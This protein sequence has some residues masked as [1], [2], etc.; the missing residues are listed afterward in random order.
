MTAPASGD[1]AA[2][3]RG[4]LLTGPVFPMVVKFGVPTMARFDDIH[5]N[6]VIVDSVSSAFPP[7]APGWAALSPKTRSC[8]RRC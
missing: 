5:D 2:K 3:T 6:L 1:K 4:E 7:A 8:S